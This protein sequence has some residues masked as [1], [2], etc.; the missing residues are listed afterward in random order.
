[1]FSNKSK[2]MLWFL[3]FITEYKVTK[4]SLNTGIYSWPVG[5]GDETK[6]R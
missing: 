3:I 1:M 2:V 5:P 6:S 4:K